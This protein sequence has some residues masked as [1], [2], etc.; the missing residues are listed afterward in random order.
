MIR[1]IRP[2]LILL[3]LALAIVA[4]WSVITD[5]I[6]QPENEAALPDGARYDRLLRGHSCV[7]ASQR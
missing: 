5:D 4:A 1:K 3:G 6:N 7:R 2:L